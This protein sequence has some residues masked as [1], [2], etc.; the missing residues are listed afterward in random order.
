VPD[1]FEVY[2]QAF[3][4]LHPGWEFRSWERSG[5]LDLRNRELFD[6]FTEFPAAYALRSDVARYEILAAH[7]GIYVDC[8][9]EPIRSFEPLLGADPFVAWCSDKELDPSVLGSPAHHPAIEKLVEDLA[10]VKAW[11]ASGKP[12]SPP[13]TT[14]P[15]FI[16]ARWRVRADV[17]RLPPSAFFPYHWSDKEQGHQRPPWPE[18]TLAVHHWNAGWK[19]D[20]SSVR[21]AA[22]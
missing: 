13:G 9:V 21:R 8:D 1:R 17:R 19:S 16:T 14:G 5:D 11:L 6:S 4:A 12:S 7:G 18:R 2:W 3:Q 15:T 20:R 10:D 22:R